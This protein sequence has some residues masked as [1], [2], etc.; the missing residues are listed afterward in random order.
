[1][2]SA[3]GT[4]ANLRI[5]ESSASSMGTAMAMS[6][7]GTPRAAAMKITVVTTGITR[8]TA[9]T[10]I[11]AATTA[12]TITAA[13]TVAI[14]VTATNPTAQHFNQLEMGPPQGRPILF[15]DDSIGAE[16]VSDLTAADNTGPLSPH[17]RS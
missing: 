16:L 11:T 15:L 10:K 3:T 17:G 6:S 14:T 8:I 1:M 5:T 2:S 9:A 12:T 13:T 7:T 4:M